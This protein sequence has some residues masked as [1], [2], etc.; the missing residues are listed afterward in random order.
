MYRFFML[1]ILFSCKE[2]KPVGQ[3]VLDKMEQDKYVEKRTDELY[4]DLEKASLKTL[5]SSPVKIDIQAII[6]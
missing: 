3:D 5:D 2:N 1:I 4:N 6:F